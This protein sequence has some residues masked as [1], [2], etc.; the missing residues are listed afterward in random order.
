MFL[1]EHERQLL[2]MQGIIA[3]LVIRWRSLTGVAIAVLAH[4]DH[5]GGRRRDG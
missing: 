5:N 4:R 3:E 1:D 2:P